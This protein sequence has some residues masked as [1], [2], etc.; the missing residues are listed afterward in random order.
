ML[1]I[2]QDKLDI[3]K[4]PRQSLTSHPQLATSRDVHAEDSIKNVPYMVFPSLRPFRRTW[5]KLIA[6]LD[7]VSVY[8][9]V[10]GCVFQ[11]VSKC[12]LGQSRPESFEVKHQCIIS[13]VSDNILKHRNAFRYQHR[14]RL[15]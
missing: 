7:M 11:N 2:D 15:L 12:R 9:M 6:V 8:G 4:P 5:R 3:S 13:T 1:A 14:A 10:V